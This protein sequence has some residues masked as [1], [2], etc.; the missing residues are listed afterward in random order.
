MKVLAALSFKVHGPQAAQRRQAT[1]KGRV[2][3]S[4][5][6]GGTVTPPPPVPPYVAAL[7]DEGNSAPTAPVDLAVQRAL[8]VKKGKGKPDE[9]DQQ[10]ATFKR[11]RGTKAPLKRKVEFALE[12]DSPA[13]RE[14]LKKLEALGVPKT[15]YPCSVPKGAKNYTIRSSDGAVLEVQHV[16]GCYYVKKT[17]GGVPLGA[18]VSASVNWARHG[19]AEAAW[20]AARLVAGVEQWVPA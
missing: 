12:S 5:V 9:K 15:A 1:Q 10:K 8:T 7:T 18:G 14:L 11:P 19:G 16:N 2:A 13:M 17:A 4:A 3:A 20:D 6:D